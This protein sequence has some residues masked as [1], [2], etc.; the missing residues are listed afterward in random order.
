MGRERATHIL[1]K[2][3]GGQQCPVAVHLGSGEGVL[4]SYSQTQPELNIF[5]APS[6][7]SHL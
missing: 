7:H 5:Q 3:V 2:T 1:C 6:A 4:L